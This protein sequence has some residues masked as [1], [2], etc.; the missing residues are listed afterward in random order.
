MMAPAYAEAASQLAP[1][2]L[3]AK[4]NTE[5]AQQSAARFNI[6]SIPTMIIFKGGKEV[7]R[8]SGA[9]NAQQINQWAKSV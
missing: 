8:Q 3:L 7:A 9:M 1:N 5:T 4:L 2:I 6:R